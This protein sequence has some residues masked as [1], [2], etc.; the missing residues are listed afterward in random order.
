MNPSFW[1]N[2][3]NSNPPLITPSVFTLLSL[4]LPSR[5]YYTS[6]LHFSLWDHNML[7]LC[8]PCY[9]ISVIEKN[10]FIVKLYFKIT[11]TK[12]FLQNGCLSYNLT[13]WRKSALIQT[14]SAQIPKAF[15]QH[16]MTE[17]SKKDLGINVI[18]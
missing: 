4:L 16:E 15:Y 11:L 9:Q 5:D 6:P 1:E 3:E 18:R 13:S 10:V 14:P 17:K 7:S 8:N 2:L 12:L